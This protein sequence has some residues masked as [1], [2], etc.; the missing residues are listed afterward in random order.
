[1]RIDHASASARSASRMAFAAVSR[2]DCAR[3]FAPI[4]RPWK[5]DWRDLEPIA[6]D[7]NAAFAMTQR[8]PRLEVSRADDPPSL[9]QWTAPVSQEGPGVVETRSFDF[10]SLSG[11]NQNRPPKVFP[12]IQKI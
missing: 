8:P 6:G 5:A 3:I 10:A 12:A 11:R 7:Y 2:A 1:M 4:R 9:R